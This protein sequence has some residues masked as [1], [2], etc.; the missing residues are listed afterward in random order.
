MS[1]LS[2]YL[3]PDNQ[4]LNTPHSSIQRSTPFANSELPFPPARLPPTSFSSRFILPVLHRRSPPW[5]YYTYLGKT[6]PD[7]KL[8]LVKFTVHRRLYLT[9]SFSRRGPLLTFEIPHPLLGICGQ[10]PDITS[11]EQAN[12]TF[13][14]CPADPGCTRSRFEKTSNRTSVCCAYRHNDMIRY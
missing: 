2:A 3:V 8:S 7:S 14:H 9:F 13:I 4:S 10:R 1:F 6:N 11:V 5:K 12:F